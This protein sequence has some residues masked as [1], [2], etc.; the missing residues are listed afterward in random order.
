MESTFPYIDP[1]A[2][3]D[4][5]NPLR[6]DAKR[7]SAPNAQ[8]KT[9]TLIDNTGC[10]LPE[11]ECLDI[12]NALIENQ[13]FGFRSLSAQGGSTIQLDRRESSHIQ[14]GETLYRLVIYRHE[15]RIEPF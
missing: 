11:A 12:L 6:E 10:N 4:I 2:N 3:F 9:C 14:V 1:L 15:A 8:G 7:Y 5:D 13:L